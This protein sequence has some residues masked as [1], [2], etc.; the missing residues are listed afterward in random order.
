LQTNTQR[1][2]Q[3]EDLL[4]SRFANAVSTRT[5]AKS[6]QTLCGIAAL[7][8]L[9]HGGLPAGALVEFVGTSCSGRTTA[10]LAYMAA[11]T[12]AGRVVA[13]VDVSDAADPES[14]AACGVDLERLLWIR[15]GA[16]KQAAFSAPS[17]PD[18]GVLATNKLKVSPQ[19]HTGGGSP[20]PR[21]EGRNMPQAVSAL[22]QNHGGLHDNRARH[23]R[24]AIGT[25]GAPNRPI[26]KRSENREEQVNSDRLPPRRGDGVVFQTRNA[27][28]L[29]RRVAETRKPVSGGDARMLSSR[30]ST[31]K[32]WPMLDQGL[33]IVDLLVQGGGF[34]AIVLDLGSTPPEAA[35]RIP[36]ATWFRFRAACERT[37][38]TLVLVTQH[39]C[40]RSSAE[41]VLRLQTGSMEVENK[42]MTGVR[43]RAATERSRSSVNG[44]KVVSISNSPQAERSYVWNVD[45]VWAQTK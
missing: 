26:A 28:P 27:E 24:R 39:P 25:P 35:W 38:T 18:H 37:R 5:Q 6:S 3:V 8:E 45:A 21:S 33:R 44:A 42:I 22:L 2:A 15:C 29:T 43:Y 30:I 10:T 7:D 13:W 17:A 9:F 41:L 20:H 40:A 14:M 11:L 34:S 19:R 31:R 4:R 1:F 23:V 32:P 16:G 36:L 12:R